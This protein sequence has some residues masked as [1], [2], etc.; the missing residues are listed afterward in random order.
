[1]TISYLFLKRKLFERGSY[2]C[3]KEEVIVFVTVCVFFVVFVVF[4][5]YRLLC[6]CYLLSYNIMKVPFI[7]LLLLMFLKVIINIPQF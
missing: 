2:S 7:L 5:F 3:S 4:T 6:I 1:M